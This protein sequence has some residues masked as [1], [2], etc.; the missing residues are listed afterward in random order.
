MYNNM[1][2]YKRMIDNFE[3]IMIEYNISI[4]Q[5]YNYFSVILYI[6]SPDA[7]KKNAK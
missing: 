7:P 2:E 4:N 5:C 3:K 1:R 6:K